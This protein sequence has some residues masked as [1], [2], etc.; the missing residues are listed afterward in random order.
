MS[1]VKTVVVAIALAASSYASAKQDP[2]PTWVDIVNPSK[3][4][5]AVGSKSVTYGP[6]VASEVWVYDGD[7]PPGN[8]SEAFIESLVESKFGLPATGTGS[9]ALATSGN[10]SGDKAGSFTIN[11]IYSYL[12][13][14][15][16]QGELLFHFSQPV[17]ANTVFT[18]GNLPHGISNYR[19]FSTVSAVPE[20]ATYGMLLSGLAL[21]G[22]VARRRTGK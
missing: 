19:A 15:Y 16:G 21:I 4:G 3:S 20:P 2:A 5:F 10:L 8:Q 6:L 12:A 1:Y 11:S 17:A 13:I 14:H 18:F 7:N 22:M 9:L